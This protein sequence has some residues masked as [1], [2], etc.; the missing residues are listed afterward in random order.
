LIPIST[1]SVPSQGKTGAW[2]GNF[3]LETGYTG[4]ATHSMDEGG[5]MPGGSS[6]CEG[7]ELKSKVG[8]TPGGLSTGCIDNSWLESPTTSAH[9]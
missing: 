2:T 9:P 8:N 1:N 4:D 6:M 3:L 7:E 5:I